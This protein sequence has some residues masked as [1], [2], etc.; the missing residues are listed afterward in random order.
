MAKK[1]A[2]ILSIFKQSFDAFTGDYILTLFN[3]G[4]LILASDTDMVSSESTKNLILKYNVNILQ[5]TPSVFQ[6]LYVNVEYKEVLGQL[7]AVLLA[8]ESIPP[9]LIYNLKRQT[10]ALIFNGYGPSE[11][12]IGICYS[13]LEDDDITI[14]RP[15]ANTQIYIL[16][17]YMR[18]TPIGVTGELCVAGDSVGA[19]YLN[20]P[21]LT[22]EKFID[23]P[24]GPGK[25]YKTGDLAYWRE[26]GNLVY[27]GRN[28]FQV[29]IRGLRIELGE[30]E[31]AL[32]T[33]EG[34]SQAVVVVRK[35]EDGQ[36]LI[37]AFYTG[38]E[39]AGATL[40]AA[41]GQRLP[42]YMLP[43]IF[44]HLKAMPLTS[45]GK[46]N[47]RVLPEVELVAPATETYVPPKGEL[48]K[49]LAAL[50]EQT[51]GYSPIGREDHFFELGG[52]SL[53]AIEFISKAHKE[54]V[55]FP[56]QYIFDCPSVKSLCDRIKS[57]DSPRAVYSAEDFAEINALLGRNNQ[58]ALVLPLEG[59]VGDLFLTGG[60][61][62]LGIHILADYLEHDCGTAYCLV[63]GDTQSASE[64]RL[65]GLLKFYFDGKYLELLGKRIQVICGDLQKEHFG[66]TD[67][68]YCTLQARVDTVINAAA[69]VKHYGSYS[70]F[71][72]VNVESVRRIIEFC[73]PAG[74]KLIHI[75]T[76]SISGDGF[77]PAPAE[78]KRPFSEQ[79]FYIGQSLE[80]VYVRSKFEAEKLVL[81]AALSGLQATIMRMGNLTNRARDGRFQVNH[82][83]NAAARRLRGLIELGMMPDYL[84]DMGVEFT[85][86][87]QAA[88]AIMTL[89]RH[90][91]AEQTV[92]HITNRKT[93]SLRTLQT[94]F[95]D[96]GYPI[97]AVNEKTFSEALRLTA[98]QAEKKHIFESFVD[99]MDA[100]GRLNYNSALRLLSGFTEKC[101]HDLGFVWGAIGEEYCK[102]YV[103]YFCKIGY[104]EGP[105]CL[106]Q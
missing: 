22:A 8:A 106:K 38:R 39:L 79:S 2:I 84:M 97:K 31:N 81:E 18:R 99:D 65:V 94:Y 21:E 15:I 48:E 104:W 32:Q 68:E 87:D 36:Q 82:E 95:A 73:R 19:G 67:G 103:D 17:R 14:G 96:L 41:L 13:I 100:N 57:D 54:G 76:L 51:L 35:R 98:E 66:L 27:V 12:T 60:T 90:F 34:V 75:S 74:A 30:I 69:S 9:G 64:A 43:H 92:F 102:K 71:R 23:N 101:L 61:G 93:V 91:T 59:E 88:E 105:I 50:M 11:T 3:G 85:P 89:V 77:E 44:I 29:K 86:V 70:Y 42:R 72:E 52:D 62:F 45:S 10:D 63:R 83:S 37:C 49:R 1:D 46:V 5:T 24:F 80:N 26:D 55:Y 7:R 33:V 4:L 6:A 53:K 28:D 16:D 58:E 20:R 78:E 25:L 56:L 40:R 47:R